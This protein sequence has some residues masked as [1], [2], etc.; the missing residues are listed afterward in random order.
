MIASATLS[1]GTLETVYSKLSFSKQTTFLLNLGNQRHN[2]TQIVCRLPAA[3]RS[4]DSLDFLLA[5]AFRG[6]PLERAI[7]YVKTRESA[8]RLWLSLSS[9][10]PKEYILRLGFCHA[11]REDRDKRRVVRLFMEGEIDIVV[12]TDSMG[13]G[14][15]IPR[16]PITVQFMVPDS[17]SDYTQHFGRG[18]RNGDPSISVL[19]VEPSVYQM[20]K[21]RK[22]T[23]KQSASESSQ[24]AAS[25]MIK[26]EEVDPVINLK[27]KHAEIMRNIRHKIIL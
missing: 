23:I 12:A 7:V 17:I 27:R 10:V 1:P 21:K 4:F 19:L 13:M 26:Q 6:E 24:N 16:C 8:M 14:M 9:K 15:D 18:G 22:P 2:I 11:V 25:L 5:P 20:I 3:A